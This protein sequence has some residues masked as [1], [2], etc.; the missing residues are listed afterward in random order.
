MRILLIS[1]FAEPIGHS[2]IELTEK[3]GRLQ[4]EVNLGFINN[5]P[6][7]INSAH[8]NAQVLTDNEEA[9][10]FEST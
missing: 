4:P 2:S 9:F 10:E 3:N 5:L 8:K 7:L 1:L 6:N